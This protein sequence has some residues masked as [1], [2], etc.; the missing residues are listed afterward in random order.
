M[1]VLHD[2]GVICIFRRKTKVNRSAIFIK[3]QSEITYLKV[4]AFERRS[5]VLCTYMHLPDFPGQI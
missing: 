4:L 5:E 3:E 1:G 2:D